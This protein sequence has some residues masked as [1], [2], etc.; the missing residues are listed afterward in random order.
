MYNEALV[1]ARFSQD[2]NSDPSITKQ[3]LCHCAIASCVVQPD[4][5]TNAQQ[6]TQITQVTSIAIFAHWTPIL[7]STGFRDLIKPK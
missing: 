1:H 3:T 5:M 4:T 6:R 2:S 7:T